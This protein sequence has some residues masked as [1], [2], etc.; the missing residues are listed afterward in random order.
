[1]ANAER[2]GIT[3]PRQDLSDA[4]RRIRQIVPPMC[5]RIRSTQDR[6]GSELYAWPKRV[7]GQPVVFTTYKQIPPL[8]YASAAALLV[9][10][11]DTPRAAIQGLQSKPVDLS[12]GYPRGCAES[13]KDERLGDHGRFDENGPKPLKI[14]TPPPPTLPRA[15]SVWGCYLMPTA[16]AHWLVAEQPQSSATAGARR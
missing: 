4:R 8:D 12:N 13:F 16:R 5:S 9:A 6:A 15:V 1:M 2:G 14:I 10:G 11:Q 7:G 3:S